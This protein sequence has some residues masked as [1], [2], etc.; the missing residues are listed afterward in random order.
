MKFKIRDKPNEESEIVKELLKKITQS[1]IDFRTAFELGSLYALKWL[2]DE[3]R[4]QIEHTTRELK[5]ENILR[6]FVMG[7]YEETLKH[8]PIMPTM[9]SK[10]K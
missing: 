6:V 2:S 3:S 5:D 4:N 9:E 10:N 8:Y 1:R 7:L